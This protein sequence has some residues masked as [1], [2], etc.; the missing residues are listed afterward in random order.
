MF[1]YVAYFF[2]FLISC[3]IGAIVG[4][5]GGVIIRPILDGLGYHSVLNIGFLS[6]SA[7][8]IMAIVSTSKKIKDGTR[9]QVSTAALISLGALVGGI[10]GNQLL[11]YLTSYFFYGDE[12]VVQKIQT[13]ATI[14]I[15]A[16]AIYF[17]TSTRFRYNL[18][19]KLL[20]PFLGVLLGSLAVFLGIGGGPINVPVFMVLFSL[21]AKQAT[22]Y[23]IVVIFFSHLF[24]IVDMGFI[25]E[26]GFGR[27]DTSFLLYIIPAAII[28]GACGAIVSKKLKDETVRK[29]FSVTMTVLIFMNIFNLVNWVLL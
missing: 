3:F 9:I 7:V 27:F 13:M 12:I 11:E 16:L 1:M 21:P 28:G 29:A 17:T 25:Q 5:G 4:L 14:V 22:A 8:L 20:F 15:L 19:N 18:K 23:S 6:S 10:F 2:I 26:G 24:R